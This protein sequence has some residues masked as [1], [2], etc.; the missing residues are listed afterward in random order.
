MLIGGPFSL[1]L[2]VTTAPRQKKLGLLSP[3]SVGLYNYPRESDNKGI[4]SS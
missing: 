3:I 4:E 2:M 1:T